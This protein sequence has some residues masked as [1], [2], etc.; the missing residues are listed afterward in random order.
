[1]GIATERR[2]SR[3]PHRAREL[4]IDTEPRSVLH[5]LVYSIFHP[6]HGAVADFCARVIRSPSES[7]IPVRCDD[8]PQKIKKERLRTLSLA[9]N[10]DMTLQRA[11]RLFDT[12]I[13]QRVFAYA[14]KGQRDAF[15]FK[16]SE[17][18]APNKLLAYMLA[19]RKPQSPPSAASGVK[20][21][22]LVDAMMCS[23]SCA[24]V[25]TDHARHE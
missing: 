5:I 9:A 17:H 4:L 18:D 25:S 22:M 13:R 8:V 21:D 6:H 3:G 16:N 14:S 1:M 24:D 7:A 10:A 23:R 15:A 11:V 12:E 2:G 19:E 20:Q